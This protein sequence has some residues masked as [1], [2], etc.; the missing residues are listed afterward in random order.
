MLLSELKIVFFLHKFMKKKMHCSD[1][2]VT[3]CSILCCRLF[4]CARMCYRPLR[5]S[6][7]TADFQF[8]FF[9][10]PTWLGLWNIQALLEHHAVRASIFRDK[11]RQLFHT[12]IACFENYLFLNEFWIIRRC[13][14]LSFL[15]PLGWS[16]VPAQ[17]LLKWV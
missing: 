13:D 11:F 16:I 7:Y 17:N 14:C 3:L 8:C 12:C 10:W 2:N 15:A 5:F 9:G 4:L 1:E 6:R